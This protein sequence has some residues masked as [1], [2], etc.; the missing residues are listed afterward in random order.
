MLYESAVYCLRGYVLTWVGA[1]KSWR[2]GL[3]DWRGVGF[4]EEVEGGLRS[5]KWHPEERIDS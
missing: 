3:F 4:G 2:E 5:E 1:R